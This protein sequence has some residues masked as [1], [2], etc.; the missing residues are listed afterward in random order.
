LTPGSAHGSSIGCVF[1][2]AARGKVGRIHFPAMPCSTI[3]VTVYHASAAE[4]TNAQP[5]AVV[6]PDSKPPVMKPAFRS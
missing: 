3:A 2:D 5:P 4:M 1:G 6:Q